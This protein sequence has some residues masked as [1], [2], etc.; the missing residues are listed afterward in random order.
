MTPTLQPHDAI[1]VVPESVKSTAH[2]VQVVFD[3]Q[4]MQWGGHVLQRFSFKK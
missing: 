4:V 2:T 3:T 1:Q